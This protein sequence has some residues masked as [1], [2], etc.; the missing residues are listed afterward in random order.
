MNKNR[1]IF[2]EVLALD[3]IYGLLTYSERILL[4]SCIIEETE[5]NEWILIL[6]DWIKK[7]GWESPKM[8]YPEF[9]KDV[10]HYEE[11]ATGNLITVAEYPAKHPELTEEINNLK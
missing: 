8:K 4:H 3:S 1:T 11:P 10:L 2:H 5:M 9:Q 6:I 7:S